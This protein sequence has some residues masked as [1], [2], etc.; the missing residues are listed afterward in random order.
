MELELLLRK[1]KATAA[2]NKNNV[3]KFYSLLNL[4]ST[5]NKLMGPEFKLWVFYEFYER[6]EQ[7]PWMRSID[8]ETLKQDARNL[9]LYCFCIG[10]R[11]QIQQSTAEVMC[12]AI[13]IAK[14]V[15]HSIEE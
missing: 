15:G 2:Y 1:V 6:Y 8:D 5:S 7:S 12:M 9:L 4:W 11:K 13:W 3:I 10:L 14:L